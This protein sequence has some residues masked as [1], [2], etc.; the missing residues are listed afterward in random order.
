M[1]KDK[2]FIEEREEA[3]SA[4]IEWAFLISDSWKTCKSEAVW[5]EY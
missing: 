4:I 5:K 3:N 2:D 1:I